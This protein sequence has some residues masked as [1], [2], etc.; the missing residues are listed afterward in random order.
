MLVLGWE[1]FGFCLFM[2][3]VFVVPVWLFVLLPLYVLLPRS[4]RLW[5]PRICTVCGAVSGAI[6][7]TLFFAVSGVEPFGLLLLF[8]PIAL[9]VGAVTCFVGS[10][11]APY[12]HGTQ[13]V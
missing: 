4:S 1:D 8:L 13:T 7:L 3:G 9:V 6:L 5:R 10:A 12:F 11:T 2:I